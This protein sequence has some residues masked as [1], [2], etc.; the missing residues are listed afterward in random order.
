MLKIENLSKKFGKLQALKDLNI[1]I[2]KGSVYSLIGP[3]GSGK[4]TTIKIITGLVKPDSGDVYINNRSI[5]KD[6]R[7]AKKYI[8]YVPDE[9]FVYGK[10]TGREIL[11]FTAKLYKVK[12]R[13]ITNK[14]NNL[15][16]MY[17]LND[18]ADGL[19]DNYSRG[20]KQKIMILSALI[21]EPKL[22]IFDEPIVGLDTHSINTTKLIIRESKR[23]GVAILISTHT[24]PFA[25][26][27]SDKVGFLNNG[28]LV[29][30]GTLRSLRTKTH[31]KQLEK[32]YLDTIK[33]KK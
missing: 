4:T 19:F 17:K 22:L 11:Q 14:I 23:K 2:E 29:E 1:E 9:P 3:N 12:S 16:E 20:N 28:I 31:D 33:R 13:N 15:L 8:G 10:L 18:I 7:N 32:M 27:I 6:P 25:E 24:L 21:H 26:T 5:A 30:E